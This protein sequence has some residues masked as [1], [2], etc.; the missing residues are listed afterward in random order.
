MFF[1]FFDY[2]VYSFIFL[3][4]LAIGSFLNCLIWRIKSGKSPAGRSKCPECKKEIAWHDNIP[5]LSF[6]FLRGKCR[7]CKKPINIQYP[8]VELSVSILFLLVF[9]RDY[10]SLLYG[11]ASWPPNF[12][13]LRDWFLIVSMIVIFVYDLR[14]YL[15]PDAIT[16]PSFF[17]LLVF[18][19]LLGASWTNLAVAVLFGGGFFLTQFFVSRGRWIGGGDIRLGAVMG[20][21]LGWPNILAALC[22]AYFSGAIV[23]LVLMAVGRK[24]LDSKLPFG[25][26]L[27]SASIAVFFLGD[28]LI[29]WYLGF[30]HF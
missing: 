17:A 20:A 22:I 4:G 9:V 18:N 5:L 19:L 26:F 25:V 27:A 16:I 21:G 24:N 7:H 23:G 30:F 29:E 2:F 12:I 13:L 14:W 6:I 10:P 11:T 15:I 8:L 1:M 28:T 3:F